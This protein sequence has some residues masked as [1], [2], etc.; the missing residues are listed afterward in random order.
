MHVHDN[1]L[2]IEITMYPLYIYMYTKNNSKKLIAI[3]NI[4]SSPA[5]EEKRG[6]WAPQ[7]ALSHDSYPVS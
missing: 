4:Y 1:Q 5:L 3:Y 2:Y 7:F 6:S